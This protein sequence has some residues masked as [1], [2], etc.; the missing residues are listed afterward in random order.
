MFRE[1]M[2]NFLEAMVV[3]LAL[4]NAFSVL[5]AAYAISMARGLTRPGSRLPDQPRLLGFLA[6]RL[7]VTH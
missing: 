6:R 2:I 5:A 3:V 1:Q 7:R 4:T